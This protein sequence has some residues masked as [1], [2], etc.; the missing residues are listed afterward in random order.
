MVYA[1]DNKSVLDIWRMFSMEH[2]Y[3]LCEVCQNLVAKFAVGVANFAR[4][5]TKSTAKVKRKVAKSSTI[6]V[7]ELIG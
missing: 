1:Y 3:R 4:I 5:S 7:Q 2:R 6:D